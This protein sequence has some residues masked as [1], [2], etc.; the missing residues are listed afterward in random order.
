MHDDSCV[1][2]WERKQKALGIETSM[3]AN[4]FR[5]LVSVLLTRIKRDLWDAVAKH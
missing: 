4:N 2:R 1:K 3:D 5:I